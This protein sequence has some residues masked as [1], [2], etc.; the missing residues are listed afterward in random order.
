MDES[1][2]KLPLRRFA[3]AEPAAVQPAPKSKLSLGTKRDYSP[4][5]LASM[6]GQHIKKKAP[7]PLEM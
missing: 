7:P 3:F 4:F 1:P 5:M 2:K 6:I